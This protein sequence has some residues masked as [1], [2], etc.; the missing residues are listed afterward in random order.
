MVDA[1]DT[2]DRRRRV[3]I[4]A[5]VGFTFAMAVIGVIYLTITPPEPGGR[6]PGFAALYMDNATKADL[7]LVRGDG[8]AYATLAQD[9][10]LADQTTFLGN[11]ATFAYFANR[12]VFPFLGWVLSAGQPA[13]VPLALSVVVGL[14][15]AA[16]LAGAV[17]LVQEQYPDRRELWALGIL[18]LPGSLTG[19][20]WVEPGMLG[21][22]FAVWGV[23][24]WLRGDEHRWL[25]VA[26]FVGAVLSRE[27]MLLVPLALA[28]HGLV[29]GRR[30]LRAFLPLL[31]VPAVMLAW[32]QLVRW[33]VG[34]GPERFGMHQNIR[35]PFVGLVDGF[36]RWELQE[37]AVFVLAVL[38][39]GLLLARHARD[40]CTWIAVAFILF[41][42]VAGAYVWETWEGFGR[43]FLPAFAFGLLPLLPR[44]EGAPAAAP[45]ATAAP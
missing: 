33:R 29:I 8:Q 39:F 2:A 35:P 43:V 5:L 6:K 38:L 30:P 4:A 3:R 14:A 36:G 9:P 11:R 13:L 1:D 32:S 16:A 19:I 40:L 27:T 31:V 12:P 25:A 24:W 18:L 7:V 37:W 21:L 28:L 44:R 10:L 22:A 20:V 45:G 26:L 23:V 34:V 41:S 15:T 17:T 42:L